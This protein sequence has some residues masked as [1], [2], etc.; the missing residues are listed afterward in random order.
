MKTIERRLAVM[1]DAALKASADYLSVQ[2]RSSL[3]VDQL[4]TWYREDASPKQIKERLVG[5]GYDDEEAGLFACEYEWDQ[6]RQVIRA[7][8]NRH[9]LTQTQTSAEDGDQ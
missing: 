5:L 9:H 4:E 2:Q 8:A 6:E 7:I 3:I 1:E